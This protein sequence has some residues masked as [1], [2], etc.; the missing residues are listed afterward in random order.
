MVSAWDSN[1]CKSV[2]KPFMK[3]KNSKTIKRFYCRMQKTHASKNVECAWHGFCILRSAY[4]V[5]HCVIAT[6]TLLFPTTPDTCCPDWG[7]LRGFIQLI[8][9]AWLTEAFFWSLFSIYKPIATSHQL[10]SFHQRRAPPPPSGTADTNLYLLQLII[11]KGTV[12]SQ[13]RAPSALLASCSTR[14][15]LSAAHVGRVSTVHFLSVPT[16]FSGH[17][18]LL[19]LVWPK[20]KMDGIDY[21][22]VRVLRSRKIK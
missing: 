6:H 5:A 14:T 1:S 15:H 12:G 13:Q 22:F 2:H 4:A 18:F 16:S 11:T 20:L 19:Q 17:R 21:V 3:W 8:Q 7:V 10:C 9:L